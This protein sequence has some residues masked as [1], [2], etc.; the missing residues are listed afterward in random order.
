MPSF[1]LRAFALSIDFFSA[2]LFAIFFTTDTTIVLF[3]EMGVLP[4]L[5]NVAV[6]WIVASP[7]AF[8][9]TSPLSDSVAPIVP[10]STKA[11]T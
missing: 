10:A 5:V 3:N 1:S 4:S 6:T 11:Y 9:V 2:S 8:A 7:D